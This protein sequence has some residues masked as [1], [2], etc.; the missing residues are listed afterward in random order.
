[1]TVHTAVPATPLSVDAP[2]DA[3]IVDRRF[4]A[5]EAFIAKA[6]AI[7]AEGTVDRARLWR[8]GDHLTR[9]GAQADLFPLA[10]F[11]VEAGSHGTVYRLAEDV[12]GRFALF[13][14]AGIA[15]K[16]VPPHDH[17]TWAIISG[18][19]GRERNV[20]YRRLADAAPGEG[21]LEKAKEQT[22]V[23]GGPA[24]TL[25]PDEVH[26]IA[27]AGEEPGLHLH[28]YG[29]SLDR[30]PGRVRFAGPEGGAYGHF[31]PPAVF[32]APRLSPQDVKAA[33]RDGAE[34]ALLDVRDEGLFA[35]GHLLFA[36]PAPL[37]RLELVID[38]LVPRRSAR[39]ILTDAEEEL[40][41]R[42]ADRLVRLGYR[43]VSVL[44]GGTAAW[45]A[46]GY[47]VF[48]GVHVPSKAFGEIVEHS[49]GT[50][51]LDAAEVKALQ[52]QGADL[53]ILD[54]RPIEE[55]RAMS[56]PGGIDCPGAEL[57]HR[58]HEVVRSP[59][60]LVVVNCAGRTRSI[61]GAQSLINA[62]LPNRVAALK[63]G[64]MGWHLAGLELAHGETR[65]A[66]PP[67]PE[68]LRQAQADAAAFADRAGVKRITPQGLEAFAAQQ[69]KRSL[70]VLDVRTPE[71]YAAGHLPGARSAPGGQLVQAT[72]FYVGTLNARIVLVD[73]EAVRAPMTASWLVQLGWDEVYVLDGGIGTAATL[74]TG[75]EPVRVRALPG[76]A[77]QVIDAAALKALQD[78]G[79]AF[80]V[81][82]ENSLDFR[83]G[84][85]PG[86]WFA[87]RLRL[88]EALAQAPDGAVIVLASADGILARHAAADLAAEGRSARVLIGGTRGWSAAGLPLEAGEERIIGL[89]EDVWYKPYDW[90]T[91]REAHMRNYL[92]WEVDLVAQIARDGD[93]RFRVI[94]PTA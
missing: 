37:S 70:F 50:P 47:E 56:I 11:P 34:L 33:L 76:P 52:D 1:M 19:H 81:D 67:S 89:G 68:A 85:I 42:A 93:S 40:S 53:V 29:L 45:A 20:F 2:A 71:E 43:N 77:P 55:F 17:T 60:T 15:G 14:S 90:S 21:R 4:A 49:L 88:G 35:R 39:I 23:R 38:R 36:A 65:H 84:H 58:A 57:V 75:P 79:H 30:L 26:T 91:D 46:A 51:R 44:A 74:E 25:L 13:A 41:H 61:I 7:A 22:A 48:S 83:R 66:P 5:I 80:V 72:D 86:A 94:G 92:T 3:G 9:L 8:I 78:E 6:R 18:V 16:A 59:Q 12:D 63:N 87:T 69:D 54:S 24:V 62:G 27:I 10:H 32:R 31:S 73:D 28:F 64:T 82:V